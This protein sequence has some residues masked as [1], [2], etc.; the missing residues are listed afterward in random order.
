MIANSGTKNYLLITASSGIYRAFSIVLNFIMRTVFIFTLGADYLGL[1]SLF[2]TILNVL[3]LTELG[4]G[5]AVTYHLYKP[6]AEN[7]MLKIRQLVRFFQKAYVVIGIVIFGIGILLI[8]FLKYLVNLDT[9]LDINLYTVYFLWLLNT[10]ISYVF[11]SYIQILLNAMQQGY[12]VNNYNTVYL[13]VSSL[14]CCM[15]LITTHDYIAYLGVRIAIGIIN[16]WMI[17]KKAYRLYP[18]LKETVTTKLPS[19]E[20]KSI[21]RDVY[22]IFVTKV[23][24]TIS[25]SVDNIVISIMLGT[26]MVGYNSNYEMIVASIQS[27]VNLLIY[28]FTSVVG[29]INVMSDTKTKI[30]I[31]RQIDLINF[32]ASLIAFC[33]VANLSNCFIRIWLHNERYVF[34]DTVVFM[35]AF[36]MF[37]EIVLYTYFVFRQAMGLF[38]YGRYRNLAV[39]IMNLVLTI[40]LAKRMG[41]TGVFLAT[42]VSHLSVESIVYP[43]YVFKYGFKTEYRAEQVRYLTKLFGGIGVVFL[44]RLCCYPMRETNTVFSFVLQGGINV[45]VCLIFVYFVFHRTEEYQLLKERGKNILKQIV[46][47]R[48]KSRSEK[49]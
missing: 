22:S 34:S 32:T 12:I 1:N 11:F 8:P 5:S 6:A 33:G 20:I 23:S 4:V 40:V 19:D 44:C 36:I 17:R 28:S 13:V 26:V 45:I 2:T 15:I 29:Q 9:R 18:Y 24:Y 42:I 3:S 35:K 31:F 47:N 41:L 38:E 46:I 43:K 49:F 16:N 30:R 48:N 14:V 39:G 37:C 7:D 10:A 25:A 21:G 27:V